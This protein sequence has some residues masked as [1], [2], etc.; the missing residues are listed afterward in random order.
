M[1]PDKEAMTIQ[2]GKKKIFQQTVVGKLDI[3]MQ[4]NKLYAYLTL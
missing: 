4:K 2:W 1:I 3:H